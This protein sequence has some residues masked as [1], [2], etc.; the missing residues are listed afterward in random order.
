MTKTLQKKTETF[1]AVRSHA[2]ELPADKVREPNM[3]VDTYVGE[4]QNTLSAARTHWHRFEAMNFPE[5]WLRQAEDGAASLAEAQARW[6][7]TRD[8]GRSQA[9]KALLDVCYTHRDD[10]LATAAYVFRD[11]D[12]ARAKIAAIREGE[13][14]YDCAQDLKDIAAL[15]ETDRAAFDAIDFSWDA[16][17]RARALSDEVLKVHATESVA[18][19]L[20][21]AKAL[22]DRIYTWTNI[23]VDEIRAAGLY[24]LRN[25]NRSDWLA[26]FRSRYA[27]ARVRRSREKRTT[28]PA[29]NAANPT[30]TNPGH[31][32][33]P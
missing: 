22:R 13:G 31:A 16:V 32:P 2:M 9:E 18:K 6:I 5:R 19:T 30:A 11:N 3:P 21:D 33:T 12:T 7:A 24:V 10:L 27:I 29:T 25:E 20:D 14:I 4:V 17:L 26:Q 23:A 8:R 28:T 1:E 15:C